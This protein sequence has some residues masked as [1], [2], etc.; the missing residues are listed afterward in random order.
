M[1]FRR[2]FIKQVVALSAL[3]LLDFTSTKPSL[4]QTPP[5]KAWQVL[6]DSSTSTKNSVRA[7]TMRS[8]GLVMGDP[9]AISILENALQDKDPEVRAAAAT[10]LGTV[11]STASIPKLEALVKD[12]EGASPTVSLWFNAANNLVLPHSRH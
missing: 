9:K 11:K 8:L 7:D 3:A 5:E 1:K 4:A 10:S 12:K 2:K 6:Q